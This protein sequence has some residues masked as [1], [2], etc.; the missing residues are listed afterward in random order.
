MVELGGFYDVG[1]DSVEDFFADFAYFGFGGVDESAGGFV[2]EV[3][4]VVL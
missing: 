3:W 4:F 2:V 1:V